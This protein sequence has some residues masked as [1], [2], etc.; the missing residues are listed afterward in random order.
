MEWEAKGKKAG[1]NDGILVV[2]WWYGVG[3][4]WAGFGRIGVGIWAV[5]ENAC[6][7]LQRFSFGKVGVAK[8]MPN[9]ILV[10]A[11]SCTRLYSGKAVRHLK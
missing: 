11:A 8:A 4:V 5:C 6:G 2:V 7:F 1:S 10:A 9:C 3:L